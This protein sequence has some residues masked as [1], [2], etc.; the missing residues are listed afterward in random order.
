MKIL[1]GVG[2]LVLI[3]VIGAQ[4]DDKKETASIASS[5]TAELTQAQKDSVKKA[6][7][8]AIKKNTITAK[9]LTAAYADNEVSAD[10]NYKD[11]SFY[12]SGTIT[13]IK[14][15]ILDNIYVTL[16]GNEM[17]RQ[18]QCYFE[19]KET[20]G[21]LQKGMKATFQGKCDGLMINVLMKDCVLYKAE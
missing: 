2:I 16:E 4:L 20:A 8:E 9:Q 1:I 18:V 17:F 14:K 13:D 15:D 12:V 21:K 10:N 11:K 6:E 19:D 7:E 3:G 5:A